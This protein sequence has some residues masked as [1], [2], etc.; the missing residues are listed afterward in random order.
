MPRL[1]GKSLIVLVFFAGYPAFSGE[2]ERIQQN[3]R[4]A[5]DDMLENLEVSY[6]YGGSKV[7]DNKTCDEC[8]QC[9]ESKKPAPKER[10][11]LC[12]VCGNC[13]LDCSHFVQLVFTRAGLGFP[14]I[15][16]TQMLDLSAESLERRYQLRPVGLN[17]EY[18]MP[19]DLLVYRGHVVIVEAVHGKDQVD[20]IHATGGRDI[21]EPGQGIQRERFV[22]MSHFR[23]ELQRVLRH[24]KLD[25]LRTHQ[26][27]AAQT[28]QDVRVTK[29]SRFKLRPIEKRRVE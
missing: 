29:A 7:G 19:G 5:G 8:N 1:F 25:E 28:E 18:V 10:F 12:A 21:R 6:V 2:L 11:K 3:V 4:L 27:S 20:I 14:Y 13:S 23:G 24:I 9:L 15:T 26:V 22:R 16:S 17:T